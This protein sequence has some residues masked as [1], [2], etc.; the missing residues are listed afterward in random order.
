VNRAQLGPQGAKQIQ[1]QGVAPPE[2]DAEWKAEYDK[3][4]DEGE[5]P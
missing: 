2:A 1:T 4:L 5:I 3:S